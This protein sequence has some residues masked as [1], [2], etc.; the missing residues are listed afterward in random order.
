MAEA[1]LS[2]IG[3][4]FSVMVGWRVSR[5][6]RNAGQRQAD[7]DF[8]PKAWER[9]DT[10]DER[11]TQTQD[12]LLQTQSEL[13]LIKRQL[14]Q[15]QGQLSDARD[16]LAALQT[17]YRDVTER[18]AAAGL[19]IDELGQTLAHTRMRLPSVPDFPETLQ[20]IA[21]GSLWHAIQDKERYDSN[22]STARSRM[23]VAAGADRTD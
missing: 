20:R 19:F 15:T 5:A 17:G 6:A 21:D 18:L 8:A 14:K 1:V 3:L 23:A 13:K 16:E 11:L 10:L 7:L 12:D 2:L 22:T 4:A 9:I